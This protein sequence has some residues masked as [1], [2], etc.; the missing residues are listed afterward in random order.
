MNAYASEFVADTI[1]IVGVGML[2]GSIAAA[3]RKRGL[4]RHVLGIGRNPQRLELARQAAI[5]DEVSTDP[6][7]AGRKADFIVVCTP[8]DRIAEDVRRIA[9]GCSRG[10]DDSKASDV[11][12]AECSGAGRCASQT[13]ITDV[14]SVK[15]GICRE[16]KNGLPSEVVFVG[17]HPLAGS[18]KSGFEYADAELFDG[19]VC[20]VTASPE[21]PPDAVR[22]VQSFWR[23]LGMVVVEL[24]PEEH[25]T[26]V[27]QT[28]HLPHVA[29]AALALAV[30]ETNQ[31]F[32]A[33]GFAD[34]T[35]IASGDP[36]LWQ[37]ILMCN[38]EAV[39]E[40]LD[41]FTSQIAAFRE[42]L[43]R[44]DAESVIELLRRA[45]A[46]RDRLVQRAKGV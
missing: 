35:R 32:T 30:S 9:A 7:E 8:V 16:L 19:A 2:G 45:K 24:S 23:G 37:S 31:P 41:R 1:A 10:R 5:V 39:V 38:A 42:A 27:A 40:Q 34:T 4:A 6:T 43:G 13:V 3:V 11:D 26:V 17:S 46:R 21:S 12:Q 28:S 44:R 14:G 15:G 20:I 36:A 29:A 18:E 22:R 25:D 33:T